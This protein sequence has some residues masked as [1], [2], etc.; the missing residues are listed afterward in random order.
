MSQPKE[1]DGSQEP[2]QGF[3]AFGKLDMGMSQHPPE[4]VQSQN[5]SKFIGFTGIGFKLL[6]LPGVHFADGHL[7][8]LPFDHLG[9]FYPKAFPLGPTAAQHHRSESWQLGTWNFC[10]SADGDSFEQPRISKFPMGGIKQCIY[11]IYTYMYSSIYIH[12]YT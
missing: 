5:H 12:M 2:W 10:A 8:W 6:F 4:M 3:V 1:E 7:S 11:C 9:H